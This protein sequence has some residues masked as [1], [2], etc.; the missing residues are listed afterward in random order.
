MYDLAIVGAGPAGIS[1][2]K[3]AAKLGLKTALIEKEAVSLGGT[4]LNRGCIPVKFL[5]NQV[6][7]G[8]SWKDTFPAAQK[9]ILQIKTHLQAFLKQQGIDIVWGQASFLD[10]HK[11]KVGSK[12]VE[13]RQ[14][15]LAAGSAPRSLFNDPKVIL[16]ENLFSLAQ[17]PDKILIL[18]AGY[19]GIELASLLKNLG[20][21]VL[22]I[23]K[24]DR[25]LPGFDT[26]LSRRLRTI[27]EKKGINIQTS[28]D[29]GQF[30]FDAFDLVIS[31]LGRVPNLDALNLQ[32]MGLSLTGTGWVKTDSFLHTDIPN[33]SACG[34]I[35]G[36]KLLAYTA[37]YQGRLCVR[38]LNTDPAA[39]DYQG[40]PECVFSS[41]QA[42]QVGILEEEAKA[43]HIRH[44]IIKSNFLKFA[45]AYVYG[46]TDG[47]I[48]VVVDEAERIIGAGIISELASELISLF[49][50]AVR[51]KLK[52]KDLNQC[53]FLHPTLSEIL[54]Q[55]LKEDSINPG[56][57]IDR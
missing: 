50:L 20:K 12:I 32:V 33:I 18:G 1:A 44:R 57:K 46:D 49:S 56:K 29:A 25:I 35:T 24:E 8:G 54:P 48:E 47:F 15:I 31:A 51:N 52:L 3:T 22:V 13:A 40:L 45:S 2:A 9:L 7:R 41:P 21:E 19:I 28:Q 4:C 42:A 36:K 23:E 5:I 10:K 26:Y 30:N 53:L 39:E 6:K 14:V 43:R 27:L 37:E 38:N 55:V 34:D 17:I 16:A 11:L